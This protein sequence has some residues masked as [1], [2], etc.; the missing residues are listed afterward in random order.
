MFRLNLH[1][2]HHEFLYIG[3]S[4]QQCLPCQHSVNHSN[5]M[6]ELGRKKWNI[7]Y[8]KGTWKGRKYINFCMFGSGDSLRGVS[9]GV[10]HCECNSKYSAKLWLTGNSGFTLRL[11]EVAQ[12]RVAAMLYWLL[13]RAVPAQAAAVPAVTGGAA[14]SFSLRASLCITSCARLALLLRKLDL[15]SC[16]VFA[17]ML[18]P[19]LLHVVSHK[20]TLQVCDVKPLGRGHR[21]FWVLHFK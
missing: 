13:G 7:S 15:E 6:I 16:S 8:Q 1:Y 20:R 10:W 12:M 11:L 21:C 17:G 3:T 2:L 4:L 9:E 18:L 19:T 5:C 14:P